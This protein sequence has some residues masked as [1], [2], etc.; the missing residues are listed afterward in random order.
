MLWLISENVLFALFKIILLPFLVIELIVSAFLAIVLDIL[1]MLKINI[2]PE[3]LEQY[4]YKRYKE[5]FG[6][7]VVERRIKRIPRIT[8]YIVKGL[9]T[10]WITL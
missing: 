1:D 3:R 10:E 5:V 6:D 9:I 8:C 2:V 4:A 7:K